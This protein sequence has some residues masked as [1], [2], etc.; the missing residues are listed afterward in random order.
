M[1]NAFFF[2][3]TK[4]IYSPTAF[5]PHQYFAFLFY[6]LNHKHTQAEPLYTFKHIAVMSQTNVPRAGVTMAAI[7]ALVS[8]GGTKPKGPE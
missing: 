8:E 7:S 5:S 4:I 1:R 2:I 3:F 6:N